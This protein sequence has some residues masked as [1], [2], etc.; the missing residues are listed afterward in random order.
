VRF[1]NG[2]AMKRFGLWLTIGI[3]FSLPVLLF[4]QATSG[5]PNT[6]I[7]D[8]TG[9]KKTTG[10]KKGKTLERKVVGKKGASSTPKKTT[11]AKELKTG[12]DTGK[13]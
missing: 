12:T 6:Q 13:K 9:K 5:S 2:Q 4:A 8:G 3:L 11:E 1:G 10:G 7:D